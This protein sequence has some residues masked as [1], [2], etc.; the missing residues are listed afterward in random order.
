MIDNGTT[1]SWF[2]YIDR[3]FLIWKLFSV[4]GSS[5]YQLIGVSY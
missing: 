5:V 2:I 1:E 3:K 4:V